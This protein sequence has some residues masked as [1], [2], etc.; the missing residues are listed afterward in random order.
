MSPYLSL[1]LLM[2]AA[3]GLLLL[4]VV[5]LMARALTRPPRMTDGK[6]MHIL[7]RLTPKDVGLR[8]EPTTFEV[9][10]V[11]A[12]G[13]LKLAAWW[14]A[15]DEASQ[16]TVVVVHG[17]ADAKVGALAWAPVWHELGFNILAVDLRA[18]GD[19]EG[20]LCTG[21]FAERHDLEQV[22]HQLVA[23]KPQETRT[24]MLFGVSLGA[25]AVAGTAALLAPIDGPAAAP[26]LLAGVVLES[27]FADFRSAS[28]AHFDLL[29][30][31]GGRIAWLA[32]R[33]AERLTSARF[34]DVRPVDLIG[35]IGC[36]LLVLAASNDAYLDAEESADIERAVAARPATAGPS[37]Y[38][39]FEGVEH[40]MAVIAEP[41][42]YRETLRSFVD[43]ADR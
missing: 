32:L 36:P 20:V 11:I 38:R 41:N 14:M 9:R 13:K 29:G 35:R 40:L 7:L 6:A 43:R 24:L 37:V 3:G 17:Y 2:L 28:M 10:D 30:L 19:S 23:G 18:H 5:H 34:D 4:A 22:V 16:K 33:H 1:T 39:R 12:D 26:P 15:A 21:G 42:D 31:P 8:F 25:A 27:P